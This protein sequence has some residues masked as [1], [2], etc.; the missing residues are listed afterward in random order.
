ML[1]VTVLVAN[2]RFKYHFFFDTVNE[3]RSLVT[4]D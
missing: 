3:L 4:V 2:E 1:G